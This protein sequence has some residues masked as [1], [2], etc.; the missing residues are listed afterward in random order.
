MIFHEFPNLDWLKSQI[1]RGFTNRL[2]WGNLPLDTEG[3]P[4]VIIHT[5]VRECF[6]PEIK[7][8][9]SFFLNIKGKSLCSV[10]RQTTHVDE[11]NYFVSN[12]AQ[13]YTLQVEEGNGGTE[14][15]N[16]H[17]GEFFSESVLNSLV[18]PADKILDAGTEKQLSPVLF[19]NQ[20]HRRDA[21]FN[22]LIQ[23][24][25]ITHNETGFNKLRFEE[26]LTA[27]LTYHLQQH[28]H[29]AQIVN[30]LPPVR[31]TTRVELYKRLSRAMDVL[32]SGFCGEVNLDL[33]AAE[34]CLSKYHFLRLFRTAYGLSPYQYIQYLRIEKARTLLTDS[35]ISI[36]EL[37][38]LLGFDNSQSFSRLFYQKMGLYPTRYRLGTK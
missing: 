15:F 12:R 18:T 34:A 20:L 35:G 31:A 19:F 11:E 1:A 14:T 17:F 38:G 2:G 26:Q 27:L 37:A 7:G 33:L 25:L 9:F 13:L 32:R 36:T 21:T 23:S 10:E 28:H 3:F 16:I 8:P 24:I 30:K 4:S 5:K 6:R 22:R 29:I